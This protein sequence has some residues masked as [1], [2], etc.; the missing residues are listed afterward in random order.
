MKQRNRWSIMS[1][2]VISILVFTFFTPAVADEPKYG[3]TLR[4]LDAYANIEPQAWDPAQFA[5]RTEHWSAMF[6]ENPL[7]GD[8][9]KGPRGT[10]AFSFQGG[11]FIPDHALT[12]HLAERWEI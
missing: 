4:V 3:G 10:N 12:G 8:L 2:L 5:W 11:A 9:S 1:G 6:W 7:Y